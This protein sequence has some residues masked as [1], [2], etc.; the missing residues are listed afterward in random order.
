MWVRVR[1][2]LQLTVLIA[3]LL[4][5]C[6]SSESVDE[7]DVLSTRLVFDAAFIAD[8]TQ[9]GARFVIDTFSDTDLNAQ[10]LSSG[11]HYDD[12]NRVRI[13]SATATLLQPSFGTVA[14]LESVGIGL[15]DGMFLSSIASAEIPPASGF[16]ARLEPRQAEELHADILK[17]SMA[18][19][20]RVMGK[21]NI[22]LISNI[23]VHLT[24]Y[25]VTV[26]CYV[27]ILLQS[28]PT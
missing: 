4:S 22:K 18:N 26:S 20:G 17:T 25:R 27:T 6:D 1:L 3:V 11:A 7:P 10:L 12:I 8:S 15:S 24:L 13:D 19:Y 23:P 16:Q 21:L 5:G 9:A 14:F 2:G 28:E